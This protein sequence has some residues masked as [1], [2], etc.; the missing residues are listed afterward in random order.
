MIYLF[1]YSRAATEQ[2]VEDICNQDG[3]APV[4]TEQLKTTRRRIAIAKEEQ[5]SSLLQQLRE[6]MSSEQLRANDTAMMKGGSSWLTLPLKSENFSLNK[7]EF[8]DALS[9]RYRWRPKYLPSMCPCGKRFDVDH[10]MSCMKGGFVHRR[11]DDVRDLFATLL[12]DVCHDVEVEPHLETLTGEVLS[13]SANSSDEARLDF[14]ARGFSQ[15]GQKA[16]FDVRVFNPFPKSHLNQK[17]DTAFESNENEKKRTYNQRV[18]EIEHGSFNPLVFTPYGGTGREAE[19]FMTELAQ[20]AERKNMTYN[21]IIHWLRSK[22]SF[23]LLKSAVMCLRGSRRSKS[24]LNMDLNGAEIS[25]IVG[26]IK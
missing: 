23:N 1:Q 2:L 6:N 13:S 20:L 22:L 15:K 26:Q 3:T 9:L 10:A 18:I 8:Y 16:F 5:S 7:R 25:K 12:K 11:H 17:L 4:D 21:T 24:D 14:S 19:R